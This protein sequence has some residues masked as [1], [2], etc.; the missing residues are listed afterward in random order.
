[1]GIKEIN[2]DNWME[3]DKVLRG[4]VRITPDGK[5]KTLAGDDY[6]KLILKPC[7]IKS[8]P[9]EVQTLFEVARGAMV[10]GYFF[11]PLYNLALEQ[12]FRVAEAAVTFKCKELNA[13]KSR[14]K[15]SKKIK[16]LVSEKI[17]R[18]EE[19]NRWDAIRHLRNFASHPKDQTILPPGSATGMMEDIAGQINALFSDS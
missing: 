16:W 1:M 13:P 19:F 2:L 11:Y 17:I 15:F 9:N 3:P 12:L 7:L 10:Y 8:V 5:S 4:F 6:L 14:D 18:E